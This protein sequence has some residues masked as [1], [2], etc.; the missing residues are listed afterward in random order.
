MA[1]HTSAG[2]ATREHPQGSII[3]VLGIVGLF[4]PL[5]GIAALVMGT[6]ALREIDASPEQYT[7]RTSVNAGRICGIIAVALIVLAAAIGVIAL[8]VNSF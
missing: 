4:V 2:A 6:K 1:E 8:V 3:L 7:N 5:V